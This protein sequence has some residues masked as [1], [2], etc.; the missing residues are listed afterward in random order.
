MGEWKMPPPPTPPRFKTPRRL[1]NPPSPPVRYG[2]QLDTCSRLKKQM[3]QSIKKKQIL[4][5]LFF[6]DIL[7]YK[8]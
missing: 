4:L 6:F 3:K 7:P 2:Y 5:F 1:C 8:V